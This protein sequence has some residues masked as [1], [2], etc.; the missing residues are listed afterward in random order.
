MILNR[1][2]IVTD[3]LIYPLEIKKYLVLLLLF[4]T[5][6]LI[7]PGIM[8]CGYLFR[9]INYTIHGYEEHPDFK[10]WKNLL[11]DGLK[12]LGLV[13]IFGIVFYGLLWIIKSQSVGV[14]NF[15][16]L[17]IAAIYTSLA[18]ALFVMCLAHMAYE[19][20]LLRHLSLKI[21]LASYKRSDG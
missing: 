15:S 12:F 1:N 13:L 10:N 3:S 14:N 16:F 5:S 2:G 8:A 20:D 4:S 9:I 6:F 11:A 17:F 18:N 19:I 7:I 21:F